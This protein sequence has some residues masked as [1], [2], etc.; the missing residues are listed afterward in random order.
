MNTL[1]LRQETLTTC[2]VCGG[3][4]YDPYNI[5]IWLGAKLRYYLCNNCGVFFLNPR[6]PDDQ[7]DEY[8]AGMYRDELAVLNRAEDVIDPTDRIRQIMRSKVQ[9]GI[10]GEYFAGCKTSLEIGCS[11]GTLM[12]E[13]AGIGI[14]PVGVEPDERYHHVEPANN[15]KCYADISEVPMVPFDLICMSHSLEHLN[16]PMDY[17]RMLEATYAHAGTRYM[18][19]VPNGEKNIV[20]R[21]HHPFGFTKA[22][23][24]WI[25]A[26]VGRVPLNKKV[27]HGLA[28]P[29]V[30]TYLLV[31][32]GR[33]DAKL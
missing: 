27:Y 20:E 2:P 26:Q 29:F 19:E 9:M 31:V 32:Y 18:I 33:D 11:M 24:D 7:L 14:V 5:T 28:R 30:H 6:M 16:H 10:C 12:H 21:P 8:Y 17:I 13:L 3:V 1:S 4:D 15:Y 22:A 23:L 25:M